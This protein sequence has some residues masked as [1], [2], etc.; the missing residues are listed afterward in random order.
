MGGLQRAT[1][2]GA[3]A[4]VVPLPGAAPAPV[5]RPRSARENDP[6]TGLPG[7]AQF[8]A[9]IGGAARRRRGDERPWAAVAVVDGVEALADRD[10]RQAAEELIRILAAALRA[11]LRDSDKLARL[12]DEEFGVLFDA[13][14]GDEAMTVL[15]RLV[16]EVRQLAEQTRHWRGI[17]LSVGVTQLWN[18]EPADA[19]ERAEAAAERVGARGGVAMS[20]ALR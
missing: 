12:G 14:Y 2:T 7:R 19:L 20:T 4:V 11:S 9:S 15:E 5:S 17:T 3:G 8:E 13:P 6:V 10:G 16:A 1:E 18:D